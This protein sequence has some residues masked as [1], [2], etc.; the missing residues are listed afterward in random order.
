[1]FVILVLGES[2]AA[3]VT[4]LGDGDW[5]R[6]SLVAAT[7]GFVIAVAFWW[8]YF[9]LSGA[10]AKRGIQDE[11]NN[12]RISVHDRYVFAHLPLAAG[13]VA[14]GV[15]VEHAITELA[16]GDL[17]EG[18]RWTLIGGAVLYLCASVALQALSERSSVW[19]LWPGLGV[20]LVLAIGAW[21]HGVA[22]LVLLAVVLV[23][24][25][26]F[27]LARRETGDLRTAEV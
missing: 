22:V 27:G 10:A 23:I 25:V 14:V 3:V 16:K 19:L 21:A 18:T 20:V 5:G 2:V 17:G 4:G 8:L 1:L 26:I 9:D 24:G 13:L 7:A 11:G 12:S 6:R 15:G